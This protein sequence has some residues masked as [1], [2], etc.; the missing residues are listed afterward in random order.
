MIGPLHYWFNMEACTEWWVRLWLKARFASPFTKWLSDPYFPSRKKTL[1]SA[2]AWLSWARADDNPGTSLDIFADSFCCCADVFT[3]PPVKFKTEGTN[4]LVNP[5]ILSDNRSLFH[6]VTTR[7]YRPNK[8]VCLEHVR[9]TRLRVIAKT[10]DGHQNH[11]DVSSTPA[12]TTLALRPV[13]PPI[14]SI[15]N[16][17]CAPL[18]AGRRSIIQWCSSKPQHRPAHCD[19]AQT[20][21]RTTHSHHHR[22]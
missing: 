3:V 2:S 10:C 14:K 15:S 19:F 20:F 4:I 21:A 17:F 8:N 13:I 1:Q 7:A 5:T 6:E 22:C 12:K 11:R 9:F 16:T 18:L